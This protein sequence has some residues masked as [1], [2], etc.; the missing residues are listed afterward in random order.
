MATALSVDL[1]ALAIDLLVVTA[2]TE[3]A[4][5]VSATLDSVGERMAG[6][7]NGCS[8]Y[9]YSR[10]SV[11]LS[12]AT[13]SAHEQGAVSMAAFTA[14][15]LE[16]VRPT[17]ACLVGI[18]AAVDTAALGLGDV[19]VAREILSYDD[20]AV[21]GAQLDFRTKGYQTDPQMRRSVG[22]IRTT[23]E[24]YAAWQGECHENIQKILG[25]LNR[26]RRTPILPPG[27]ELAGPHLIDGVV[28]G[29]PFLLR[30]SEFRDRLRRRKGRGSG[31]DVYAPVHT[32][33][34]SVEMESHGFMCAA[35]EH[36]VPATVIKGV[37][38]VGDDEKAELEKQSGGFYRAY[39]CSNAL[40]AALHCAVRC[41]R[42]GPGSL[43]ASNPQ[44]VAV[45]SPG[46][47]GGKT[48]TSPA[49]TLLTEH[50]DNLARTYSES[51]AG[52]LERLLERAREG[53]VQAVLGSV[54]RIRENGEQWQLLEF[55]T[56]A[57]LLCL[58]A[59]L[60]LQTSED[61]E[62]A[63][64]LVGMSEEL[65][66][67]PSQVRLRAAIADHRGNPKEA[68]ELLEGVDDLDS[69]NAR[70]SYLLA[71]GDTKRCSEV[72]K[73]CEGM[74]GSGWAEARRIAALLAVVRG[75][76]GRAREAI[77][78]ARG[79]AARWLAVRVTGI[80]VDYFSAL[81]PAAW[82]GS[83]PEVPLPVHWSFV[84]QDLE[85]REHLAAAQEEARAIVDDESLAEGVRRHVEAWLLASLAVDMARQED[86][87][88]LAG[89]ILVREPGHQ[90][91]IAW[92]IARGYSF[93]SE[94]AVGALEQDVE[95]GAGIANV[96]NLVHLLF[97][98]REFERALVVLREHRKAFDAE[99]R[100]DLA[101]YWEA[102]LLLAMGDASILERLYDDA[103]AGL[104]VEQRASLLHPRAS[105]GEQE[106]NRYLAWLGKAYDDF[107]DP[108]L[109]IGLC[110]GFAARQRWESVQPH[111]DSLIYVGTAECLLIAAHALHE[112]GQYDACVSLLEAHR[113]AF[114]AELPEGVQ[115]LQVAA[116]SS[117]G[118]LG[119]AQTL[120]RGLVDE[121][122]TIEHYNLLAQV[123]LAGG[124]LTS[125]L[126]VGR[127]VVALENLEAR[128][129]VQWAQV[130]SREDEDL[131]R[132]LLR[133]AEIGQ[134]PDDYVGAAV[135][136][137]LTLGMDPEWQRPASE[138]LQELGAQGRGGIRV[139][140]GLP[141]LADELGQR[142]QR[143]AEAE[144][145]YRA[146][147][148]AIHALAG[149]QSAFLAEVFHSL[150][151]RNREASDPRHRLPLF[152][153]HGGR[154]TAAV[155]AEDA[156]RWRIRLDI[157][158][159]LLA[160]HLNILDIVADTFGGIGI[161]NFTVTF[162]AHMRTDVAS[163]AEG[164]RI[165]AV[166]ETLK[167]VRSGKLHVV[168]LT[169]LEAPAELVSELG[170]ATAQAVAF[171]V[172]QSGHLV[173]YPP[174][175]K[176]GLTREEAVVPEF[177]ADRLTTLRGVVDALANF[178]AITRARH[179]SAVAR[180]GTAGAQ[181]GVLPD[182]ATS[183]LFD[184]ATQQQLAEADVLAETCRT[185]K[186]Y[187]S[188]SRREALERE[189]E[190]SERAVDVAEWVRNLI[191]WL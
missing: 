170:A 40:L 6:E 90:L 119:D 61:T 126:V 115:R 54:R 160:H 137:G 20:V 118:R 77:E 94:V 13:A 174:L 164:A 65:G 18:A 12:V 1:G 176:P 166:R 130:V 129:A 162:L 177:A 29:G 187:I 108:N 138:R 80:V 50:F 19:P 71:A 7:Y 165:R 135:V 167:A 56:R 10:G 14:R 139:G 127:S 122:P 103:V 184:G 125:L 43:R 158:G 104:E 88:Q 74:E 5:V 9:D 16:R 150:L 49:F 159:L 32:K 52:D 62:E 182:A 110:Q 143:A 68:A 146:G 45:D 44:G 157:T 120:A 87:A 132:A 46:R 173:C 23:T 121:A 8:I 152:V 117:L 169:P 109:L 39:A 51:V 55:E 42:V 175:R 168:Q 33:L 106:W 37:C 180:L 63:A 133:R 31:I 97:F 85:S 112:T 4:Q 67:H 144:H 34:V 178:R 101:A 102:R 57:R 105:D 116:L 17:A 161:P 3:E 148:V 145:S 84:K 131:A 140:G 26:L 149:T 124:D 98:A 86:A 22:A 59:G 113:G 181:A 95:G 24:S 179:A 123:L 78:L 183:L 128:D 191:V 70:G 186:C 171:A 76:I 142:R 134:V 83:T 89:E 2:L 99:E 38:D 69:L 25:E 189:V 190:T 91:A 48:I 28:A 154:P 82:A 60:V 53:E 156:R 27:E 11:R 151:D 75:D 153:R 58:E 41:P 64:T 73:V 81:A 79:R 185:F 107:Q 30:D 35:L 163:G 47:E 92:S 93:D 188:A 72:V 111:V 96:T 136:L 141:A 21:Q 66:A 155:P 172:E 15:L 36:N 114:G 100:S 147:H